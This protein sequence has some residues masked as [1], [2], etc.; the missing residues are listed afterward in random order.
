[1]SRRAANGSNRA[2]FGIGS[3]TTVAA[4]ERFSADLQSC[5]TDLF[6]HRSHVVQRRFS[7]F[8]KNLGYRI[9]GLCLFIAGYVYF[10]VDCCRPTYNIIINICAN[11]TLTNG[12]NSQRTI[13]VK[14]LVYCSQIS[15]CKVCIHLICTRNFVTC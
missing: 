8:N 15:R 14:S 11:K 2:F 10:V 3:F 1:M 4:M 7:Y 13:A 6:S 5:R 12:L 9:N